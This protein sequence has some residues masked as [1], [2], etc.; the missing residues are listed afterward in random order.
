MK[1]EKSIRSPRDRLLELLNLL[2]PNRGRELLNPPDER[3]TGLPPKRE[4]LG[5]IAEAGRAKLRLF[6]IY[7]LLCH[8]HSHATQK[9]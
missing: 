5:A 2:P 9:S 4:G 6:I 8:G 1:R 3:R 7:Y